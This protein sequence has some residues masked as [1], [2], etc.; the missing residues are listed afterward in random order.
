MQF[1]NLTLPS[2]MI[3]YIFFDATLRDKFVKYAEQRSVPCTASD[4]NMGMVVA[5]PEDLDDELSEELEN[6]YDTLEDEQEEISRGEGEFKS[7]A[8]FRFN[9]PD[10]Q[11]RMLPLQT[12]MAN[13]LLASFSLEEIQGLFEAVASCTLNPSDEHLCKILAAQQQDQ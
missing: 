1:F 12:A 9:L 3:E 2:A 10:G 13:R 8:G 5:I 6:Y 4:D 11:S 7:L